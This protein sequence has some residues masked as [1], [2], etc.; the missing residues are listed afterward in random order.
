LPDSPS[1]LP[2]FSRPVT[3]HADSP[4]DPIIRRSRSP[5]S[6]SDEPFSLSHKAASL[7]G[8]QPGTL[9]H[10]RA[11]LENARDEVRRTAEVSSDSELPA[12]EG[13]SKSRMARARKVMSV[14]GVVGHSRT[15]SVVVGYGN[16]EEM[17][18][19]ERRRK[20][21]DGVLYWQKEVERLE[22]EEKRLQGTTK[23]RR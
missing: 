14:V 11:S 20:A 10:A 21:A 4:S 1:S 9:P 3:P 19:R 22:A 18:R 2:S 16:E 23:R 15:P 5:P 17:K 6:S 7:L 8:L 13:P 12:F